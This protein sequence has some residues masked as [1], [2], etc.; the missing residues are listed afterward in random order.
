MMDN[1]DG[2][3]LNALSD[4][5]TL[6]DA[7]HAT[8][9]HTQAL[10]R[11]ANLDACI[12]EYLRAAHSENTR[13]AYAA[14]LKHFVRWGGKVPSTPQEI[15]Q[16]LTA[17]ADVLNTRTLRRRLAALA[18]AHTEAGSDPTKSLLITRLMRG[19]A[20]RHEQPPRQATPILLIDL[21]RICSSM[22]GGG[23][24]AL[25]DRAILLVGFFAA[26]RRSEIAALEWSDIR[27]GP[28][29]CC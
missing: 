23:V 26:L 6:P 1:A 16:Y 11:S 21:E 7:G 12:I 4:K 15:A 27:S 5:R 8:P 29:V 3:H 20:R 13:R 24:S 19:I 9:D 10:R 14:D 18:H 17:Q 28:A 2:H 22:D 25:R